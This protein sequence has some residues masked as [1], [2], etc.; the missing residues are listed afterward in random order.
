MA[1]PYHIVDFISEALNVRSK[2]LKGSKVL[3]LGVS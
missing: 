3:I 2:A 1:M